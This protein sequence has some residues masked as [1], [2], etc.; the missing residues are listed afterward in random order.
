[1][2]KNLDENRGFLYLLE[3]RTSIAFICTNAFCGD[4]QTLFSTK[5]RKQVIFCANAQSDI[6]LAESDIENLWFQ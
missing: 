3:R 4:T 5:K 2:N 1:M 6:F